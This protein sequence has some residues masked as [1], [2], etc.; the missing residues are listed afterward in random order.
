MKLQS[1]FFFACRKKVASKYTCF[2]GVH[3]CLFRFILLQ[4][5]KL[6]TTEFHVE[7]YKF[8]YNMEKQ[9]FKEAKKHIR[10]PLDQKFTFGCYYE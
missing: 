5:E 1:F 2:V 7:G 8:L 9:N 3:Q 10:K 6:E 4:L